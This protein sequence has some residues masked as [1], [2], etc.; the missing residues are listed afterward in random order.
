MEDNCELS[1]DLLT[2]EITQLFSNSA[3][4]PVATEEG[5]YYQS[6]SLKLAFYSFEK[7]EEEIISEDW[8]DIV[9]AAGNKIF[10]ESNGVYYLIDKD[11]TGKVEL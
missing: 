11:G 5:L 9:H 10:Y 8:V 2:G 3:N 7:K 4:R 6:G 1:C